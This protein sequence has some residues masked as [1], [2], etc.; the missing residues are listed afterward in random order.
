MSSIPSKSIVWPVGT[1][2]IAV[3][4]SLPILMLLGAALAPGGESW[5]HMRD[6]V[7]PIYLANTVQ[8]MVLVAAL[9]T[10]IG[11][12][13]AWLTVHYDFPLRQMLVPALAL[14]LAA[15]AYVIGYVYADLLEFSGPVQIALR[16]WLQLSPQAVVLPNIRSLPGAGLVISLV[17]YP[18]VYLLARGSFAQQSS[19]LYEAARALGASRLRV[20]WRVALPVAWPAVVG[21]LA[22]VLMETVA[23]Y[24][25]VEHY[26]VP[27]LTTGI[28]RT[29]FAMGESAA[30]LQLA[31]WLFVVVCLLVVAEQFARRG[32]RFNP[33]GRQRRP[34]RHA[35]TGWSAWLAFMLCFLPVLLGLIVPVAALTGMALSYGETP[36]SPAFLALVLN[37]AWV[38]SVA[39]LLCAGAALWL[40]YAERLHPNVWV[41]GGVRVA[42]L[43]YAVPGLVLA[44]ALMVPLTNLDKWLAT[45]L[46]DNF[47]VHWGLLITGSSAALILVYVAR[48]LTV[49]FNSTQAGLT[50]IHPQLDAAARSL[51]HEPGVVLRRVHLPLLRPAVITG[52]L[53]VFIDVMKELP[54]TLI[55]RPFNFE[56]LA[57]WVY[58]F[59]SDERLAQAS[60]AALVIVLMS[61]IPTML[62][63]RLR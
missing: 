23:D 24:G 7:F 45:L 48:F 2:L 25:V 1:L 47:D 18:Y 28:F 56:T 8:L 42:T 19:T 6:T 39:A 36:F 60:T 46:R 50:Q 54:A 30:A 59:A 35:L 62:L 57:T 10:V 16:D 31:G 29:W 51:G 11:V 12:L 61:L 40:A 17:L 58:R 4:V 26:G 21:G 15:P 63:S 34:T 44:V 5:A 41:R 14:P 3:P 53:L 20:F 43:G 13:T 37:S 27:T 22:L 52:L 55:L 9:S 49:A 32:Q 38:A 33:V